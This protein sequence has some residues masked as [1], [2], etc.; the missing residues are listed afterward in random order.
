MKNNKPSLSRWIVTWRW[1]E[2]WEWRVERPWAPLSK[3]HLSVEEFQERINEKLSN[4][5]Y[6]DVGFRQALEKSRS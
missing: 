4:W 5:H 1:I 6:I 2:T 3:T